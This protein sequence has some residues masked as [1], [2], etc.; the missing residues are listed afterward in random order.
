LEQQAPLAGRVPFAG[1]FPSRPAAST[2]RKVA[3]AVRIAN[4]RKDRT[5]GRTVTLDQWS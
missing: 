4:A 5:I 3:Q 2:T 1:V